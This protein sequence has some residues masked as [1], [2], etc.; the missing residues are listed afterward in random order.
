MDNGFYIVVQRED[1]CSIEEFAGDKWGMAYARLQELRYSKQAD[2][3][4]IVM[5]GIEIDRFE[6]KNEK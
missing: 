5:R 6:V 3:K 2:M 4:V 1:R